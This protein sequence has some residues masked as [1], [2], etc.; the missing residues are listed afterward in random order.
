MN[1]I[2]SCLAYRMAWP[3]SL[4]GKCFCRPGCKKR[5]AP[6][7]GGQLRMM[8]SMQVVTS[9][10]NFSRPSPSRINCHSFQRP[11]NETWR[12]TTC[13]VLFCQFWAQS[14]RLRLCTCQR[15]R[16]PTNTGMGGFLRCQRLSIECSWCSVAD[17]DLTMKAN[18]DWQQTT[19]ACVLRSCIRHRTRIS[20]LQ[21]VLFLL[22]IRHSVS[23]KE[24]YFS[25]TAKCKPF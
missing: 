4:V 25:G 3:W 14:T 20:K 19:F 2:L 6:V 15:F 21:H 11:W 24:R 10:H 23:T 1:M 8:L 9:L 12:I 13:S 16:F 18:Q 7:A 22:G 5:R 17:E